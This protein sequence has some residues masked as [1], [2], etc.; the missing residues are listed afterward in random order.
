MKCKFFNIWKKTYHFMSH[1]VFTVNL[2]NLMSFPC[3]GVPAFSLVEEMQQC[4]GSEFGSD[5]D[6]GRYFTVEGCASKCEGLA[7]MFIF[8][9]NKFTSN[10]FFHRCS[11]NKCKC[12]C[13]TSAK[14]D[15]T[16]NVKG[17]RGF[18]LYKYD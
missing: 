4:S 6:V 12:Y 15:G 7:S 16:C 8:G 10:K 11:R 17:H 9:T 3:K 2:P 18:I 13:E 5:L 1:F 14:D